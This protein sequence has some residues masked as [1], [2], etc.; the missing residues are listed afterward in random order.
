MQL[1][2][3]TYIILE[4]SSFILINIFLRNSRWTI[5]TALEQH[6]ECVFIAKGIT[7]MY[8]FLRF[9]RTSLH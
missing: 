3:T 8:K 6:T 9:T 7:R 5:K 4:Q 1:V 2:I